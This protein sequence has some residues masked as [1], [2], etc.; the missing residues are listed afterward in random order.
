MKQFLKEKNLWRVAAT[1]KM[2]FQ[3]ILEKNNS[4]NF[5]WFLK[6]HSEVNRREFGDCGKEKITYPLKSLSR[7]V[8]T[9]VWYHFY[10][11]I[12]FYLQ[13][14]LPRA[15]AAMQYILHRKKKKKNW[16]Q[17]REE[18]YILTGFKQVQDHLGSHKNGF[19]LVLCCS[20]WQQPGEC[21]TLLLLLWPMFFIFSPLSS[22]PEYFAIS[23]GDIVN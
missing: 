6:N 9:A 8:V 10:S 4:N 7:W 11:I 14:L 23:N 13:N 22:Q 5:K 17:R 3:N 19:H 18:G 2:R 21:E 1:K 15:G 12:L 20:T 16:S